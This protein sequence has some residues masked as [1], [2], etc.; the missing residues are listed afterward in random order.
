[1]TVIAIIKYPNPILKKVS[2]EF[3][4]DEI[5]AG[6]IENMTFAE[7]RDKMIKVMAMDAGVGLAAPQVGL[8]LRMFIVN[9]TGMPDHDLVVFN[10]VLSNMKGSA[11]D[12]EGCLS[13]PHIYIKVKR[14]AEVTLEGYDVLSNPIKIEAKEMQA[15]VIQHEYDHCCGKLFIEK[16]DVMDRIRANRVLE[17]LEQQWVRAQLLKG[18][19]S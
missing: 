4:L 17:Q 6:K 2:R 8:N 18:K 5:K 1:M 9:T 16:M 7:L 19:K 13:F 15:R 3:T 11:I 14:F 12:K 10:P